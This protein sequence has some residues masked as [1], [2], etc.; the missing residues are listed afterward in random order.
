MEFSIYWCCVQVYFYYIHNMINLI[1]QEGIF[2]LGK[3]IVL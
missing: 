3:T 2:K 1:I